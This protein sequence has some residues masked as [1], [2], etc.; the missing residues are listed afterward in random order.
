MKKF[1]LMIMSLLLIVLGTTLVACSGRSPK[2][3]FTTSE[4]LLSVGETI[5]L[6]DYLKVSG[7]IK[8]VVVK[9]EDKTIVSVEGNVVRAENKG[10]TYLYA[11]YS[12][13]VLAKLHIVVKDTFSVP[14][15][16]NV[17]ENGKLLSENGEFT[18]NVV[19]DFYQDDEAPTIASQYKVF[20]NLTLVSSRDGEPTGEREIDTT[21]STNKYVPT[22]FGIYKLKVS[23]VGKGYFDS[24][25][26]S[27]EITFYYG[28]MPQ[29][30]AEDIEWTNDG[31]LTW[32]GVE[33]ARYKV[34]LDGVVL[35]DFLSAT[36]AN[37]AEYMTNAEGGSHA[38]EVVC[39]DLAGEKLPTRS[40]EVQV[41]KLS[42]PTAEYSFDEDLGGRVCF[43]NEEH[44]LNYEIKISANE[45]V[46]TRT[47]T[48]EAEDIELTFDGIDAGL[49]S[50]EIIAHPIEG[51][52]FKSSSAKVENL[53]KLAPMT[54]TGANNNEENSNTWGFVA[55]STTPYETSIIMDVSGTSVRKEGF[56]SG[57]TRKNLTLELSQVGVYT[58]SGRHIPNNE[59]YTS[60]DDVVFAINSDATDEIQVNKLAHI[61]NVMHAYAN[62]KSTFTLA[63]IENATKYEMYVLDGEEYR[64]LAQTYYSV[65]VGENNVVIELTGKIEDVLRTY[66]QDGVITTKIVAKT[67]NDSTTINSSFEKTLTELD[68]PEMVARQNTDM[69]CTWTEDE[70]VGS[71][72][73][74]AYKID[75]ATYDSGSTDIDTTGLE[76]DEQVVDEN[77]YDFDEEGY[78]YVEVYALSGNENVYISATQALKALVCVAVQLEVGQVK[79]GYDAVEEKY[80][81][82]VENTENVDSFEIAIDTF[83]ITNS[84]V[85]GQ[86]S[87]YTLTQTFMDTSK[88]YVVAI[89][90]HS[91]DGDLYLD[92]DDYNLTIKKLPQITK[93]DVSIDDWTFV[94]D[95][96]YNVDTSNTEQKLHIEAVENAK[97][98]KLW[99]TADENNCAG[100][101]SARTAS[102]DL[103]GYSTIDLSFKYYGSTKTGEYFG[104]EDHKIFLDSEVSNLTFTRLGT[105]SNFEYEDG[106]LIVENAES[107]RTSGYT[108]NVLCRNSNNV[109]ENIKVV[110]TEDVV[111]IYEDTEETLSDTN[112]FVETI[113]GVAT[114]D[115]D[116]I[117]NLLKNAENSEINHAYNNAVDYGFAIYSMPN[118]NVDKLVSQYATLK[119]DASKKVAKVEKMSSPE[120][121]YQLSGANIIFNWEEVATSTAAA[122]HTTYQMY[123]N[124]E[125]YGG[126]ISGAT[127][128][129]Y[130]LSEFDLST[131]YSFYVVAE[132][133]YYMDSNNSNTIRIYKLDSIN[134]IKMIS[135]GEFD[136]KLEY[137]IKAEEQGF[138]DYVLVGANDHNT[139]GKIDV[140]GNGT[141][142]LKV[143]GKKGLTSGDMTTSYL[144]SETKNWTLTNMSTLAPASVVVSYASNIL[145][146]DEFAEGV[147]LSKLK[148]AVMFNDGENVA[149]YTTTEHSLN[150]STNTQLYTTISALKEGNIDI[151]VYAFLET[152]EVVAGGNVYYAL[153]QQLENG[154]TEA[155]YFEYNSPLTIKKL[156]TPVIS[157]LAFDDE[158]DLSKANEPDIVVKFTGNYDNNG[159]F[160]ILLNNDVLATTNITKADGVYT[161]TITSDVYNNKI[162]FGAQATIKIFA[163]SETDIPSSMG[164]VNVVRAAK[165]TSVEFE[166]VDR[167]YTQKIVVGIDESHTDLIDGGLV[168]KI[169]YT[170]AGETEVITEYLAI[171]VADI[172]NRVEYSL[173]DFIATNLSDGGKIKVAITTKSSADDS[174]KVY[175]LACAE[176]MESAEYNVLSSVK[177]ANITNTSAGFEIDEDLNRTSTMYVVEYLSSVYEVSYRD[178]KFF[179]EF[180]TS[181]E[182]GSY[183][184]KLYATERNY[185][186]SVPNTINFVLDRIDPVTSVSISRDTTDLSEVTLQWTQIASASGYVLKM[187]D[188]DD[189]VIFRTQ[190]T[191][192][193]HTTLDIF[194]KNF[195]K[196][197]AY[198]E[199]SSIPNDLDVRIGISAIG[200]NANANNSTEYVFNATIK[201]N[202]NS[203]EDVAVNEYGIVTIDVVAGTKYLY[204]FVNG[205]QEAI[206]CSP[207]TIVEAETNQLKI[208]ASF[209]GAELNVGAKVNLEI[210]VLGNISGSSTSS[211]FILDSAVFTTAD[212]MF[213]FEMGVAIESV[214]ID[215]GITDGLALT[216]RKD[217]FDTIFFGVSEDAL[218]NGQVS[219]IEVQHVRDVDVQAV[220]RI[221]GQ[222]LLDILSTEYGDTPYGNVTLYFWAYQEPLSEETNYITNSSV[223]YQFT[224]VESCGYDK[225][226]KYEQTPG[227]D[228]KTDY[229]TAHIFLDKPSGTYFFTGVFVRV[230]NEEDEVVTTYVT[231]LT[232]DYYQGANSYIINLTKLFE[233]TELLKEQFGHFRVDIAT[234]QIT[235]LGQIR[236]S[237]WLSA[238]DDYLEFDRVENIRRL[239]LSSGQ[240]SWT[241]SSQTDDKY[242]V[243]F[244]EE[245]V[246]GEMGDDFTRFEVEDERFTAT[247]FV[248]QNKAYYIAIQA[249]NEDPNVLPSALV[250]VSEDGEP[251]KVTKN[252]I[253]SPLVL[254]NGKFYFEWES[255]GDFIQKL[256]A[257]EDITAPKAREFVAKTYNYPFTFT[258]ADL[259]QDK[260]KIRFKFTQEEGSTT[261]IKSVE[262]N[263]KDL[264][265]NIFDIDPTLEDKIDILISKIGETQIVSNLTKFKELMKNGNHGVASV[266]KIFDDYFE[267]IQLGR[268]SLEYCM[269]GGNKTLNSYW[270]QFSNTNGENVV[271]VGQEPSVRPVRE[272]TS[273]MAVNH[274]KIILRKSYLYDDTYAQQTTEDYVLKVY[275]D[276]GTSMIFTIQKL[277]NTYSL[278]M[279]DSENVNSVS[280]YETDE[281]GNIQVDGNYL[282]F[283][284]NHH[285]NDSLLGVYGDEITKGSYSMELYAVG[286]DITASSKSEY[287]KLTLYGM[288]ENFGI[289]NGIFTWTTQA[290]KNTT[291]VYKRNDSLTEQVEVLDGSLRSLSFN[292]ENGGSGMYDYIQFITIGEING[293]AIG[294]D[295]E[296][297][298][299]E[300]VYKLVMPVVQNNKGYLSINDSANREKLLD[301]FSS[302]PLFTYRVYNDVSTS[303]SYMS[304]T[305]THQASKPVLYET[306]VNDLDEH[307]A[308]YGYRETE[309]NAAKFYV[310]S[311]GSTAEFGFFQEGAD[312]YIK[313][314]YGMEDGVK[315][316]KRMIVSSEYKE[317]NARMMDMADGIGITN[318]MLSW[319][320][321]EGRTEQE[322][323]DLILN[324]DVDVV[325]RVAVAKYKVSNTSIGQTETIL[326][327]IQYFY[328]TKLLFDFSNVAESAS[329]ADVKYLKASV[330]AFAMKV[331]AEIPEGLSE[332]D[333]L[334]LVEGGYAFGNVQYKETNTYVLMS[335]AN[336]LNEIERTQKVEN[337][338]V[339]N[340]KLVWEFVVDG[341]ADIDYDLLQE[342][343]F[344]VVDEALEEVEGECVVSNDTEYVRD[345]DNNIVGTK[346]FITFNENFGQ[347]SEGAQTLTIYATRL[348]DTKHIIRSYGA[349]VEI[350]KLK[351]ITE[352]DFAITSTT[353][354]SIE[355]LDISAYFAR[356]QDIN[357]TIETNLEDRTGLE[358]E[359]IIFT[360][361]KTLLYIL[362]G[363]VET[364][365]TGSNIAGIITITDGSQ[366]VIMKAITT[367]SGHLYSDQTE[368]IVLQRAQW[369]GLIAWDPNIQQFEWEYDGKY[370]IQSS[371]EAVEVEVDGSSYTEIGDATLSAG[372]LYTIV[373]EIGSE[374]VI[375]A[376]VKVEEV[377][378][379]KLYRIAKTDAIGPTYIVEVKYK[380]AGITRT[381]TTLQNHFKP[382]LIDTQVELRLRIKLGPTNIQ[383]AETRFYIENVPGEKIYSVEFNLFENLNNQ[384]GG[385]LVSDGT[386]NKPYYIKT[387]QQFMNLS[388]RMKKDI[389]W[390]EYV[391]NGS[392]IT[393]ESVFYFKLIDDITLDNFSGMLFGNEFGGVIDGRY[394]NNTG[395]Y[396]ITY[397]AIDIGNLSS[398][399][400]IDRHLS[401]TTDRFAKGIALF[402]KLADGAV[403]KNID[404]DITY[405]KESGTISKNSL[406]AGLAITNNGQI[407]NVN[408]VNFSTNL[409]GNIAGGEIDMLYAGLV[410]INIGGSAVIT[411]CHNTADMIV[412][413]YGNSQRNC[414]AGIVSVNYARVEN[415]VIGTS[416]V[417][418]TFKVLGEDKT[419]EIKVSGVATINM[420]N[421]TI[422]NCQ[423]YTLMTAQA[424]DGD[425]WLAYFAGIVAHNDGTLDNT[426]HNYNYV[427]QTTAGTGVGIIRQ[428]E[429]YVAAE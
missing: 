214:G 413:T 386:E 311:I 118:T 226:E 186:Q 321:V 279:L 205:S 150:F 164:S 398:E 423:N 333:C 230:I 388:M 206:T 27:E 362:S 258:I 236:I 103:T 4:E 307:D 357:L 412:N 73:V 136:G 155:N 194:G 201:G 2:A 161:Y 141:I 62:D 17:D 43:R 69:F 202:R 111:A 268:Y 380:D 6:K 381:Y 162:A 266:G 325:Y 48:T 109:V 312:Y 341:Q 313:T 76:V 340:G 227:S 320:A 56:S 346:F 57:V 12:S 247:D 392:Q 262:V 300:D 249:V 365:P 154:N 360:R 309:N 105:L 7:N 38:I 289:E 9:S 371:V 152:Y 348:D 282:M 232:S 61:V 100:S 276:V 281:N 389:D 239:N 212:K 415:C 184:L 323:S 46:E 310:S 122:A 134:K 421:S 190:L 359:D 133:P 68:V 29:I 120:I 293:N 294:V 255:N 119:A 101:A 23:A 116:G 406:F 174:N 192:N 84:V 347:I 182:N 175:H 411:N 261:T 173:A 50:V 93:A 87:K 285:N 63:K 204:R 351:T 47:L 165:I 125:E 270:Y 343:Q 390:T 102:F 144:D 143:V 405:N 66:M 425:D 108:I 318:G 403:I 159:K 394:A 259:V 374:V 117:V 189:R 252:M 424:I 240:L 338:R 211:D 286:N 404:L 185:V 210:L 427:E 299:I 195:S 199:I 74:L 429:I 322:G 332:D 242:Y 95:R 200:Q 169:T 364:L 397:T 209:L 67:N 26:Q 393:E 272:T 220:Y 366:Q 408:L 3:D 254:Q 377:E 94:V 265:S 207:W 250:Y 280:V 59:S 402:E 85:A 401:S 18:W 198:G 244:V 183:D 197:V 52:Y 168:A 368:D 260:I 263:A 55:R 167:K 5:N 296:I 163:L 126:P 342:Y 130:S 112:D 166:A 110:L 301:G 428:G 42:A 409:Q 324:P 246:D 75:K 353:N 39:Y 153:A 106:K 419:V 354:S 70:N 8:N 306:G 375:E 71:Y 335:E 114:I 223:S 367:A 248:G 292:I 145:S 65:S 224:Y 350:T 107:V 54:I 269:V 331:G 45:N 203:V 115:I 147:G 295:S 129:S 97:G 379:T 339:S 231:D 90:A 330:K 49:F 137:Q 20:G 387:K 256:S 345:G 142:S 78:Y 191:G 187:Y 399:I 376:D 77:R 124:G 80:Y 235:S 356:Y 37:I 315:S 121:E 222:K 327:S 233:Q 135:G 213:K 172:T 369:D 113:S 372:T 13:N 316:L 1:R 314:I 225:V 96:Y 32:E 178:D 358:V 36:T 418:T 283:Y 216:I 251:V 208:D 25:E 426:N 81:L 188:E 31:T 228:F 146:W 278:R 407:D 41:L 370:S 131:Y 104:I 35:G 30:L 400:I 58:I 328:T 298:R 304:I 64:K 28:A 171:P 229:A 245:L 40:E 21:V 11:T 243:Y 396:K 237:N 19:S 305:D 308:D 391:E 219:E 385:N 378:T 344:A 410:S 317:T 16:F 273:S 176:Y 180:D 290:N 303:N 139:T 14:T 177:V 140:S 420:E 33:N 319:N 352:E 72:R 349:E 215:L 288:G 92:S 414:I 326:D 88:T 329:D 15:G 53:Y 157:S 384:A 193:S 218:K 363:D 179:F 79:F 234:L 267:A 196:V 91:N 83:R 253:K 334:P 274:Y 284:I 271:Y 123:V 98:V 383:S 275:N 148:Y 34:S 302:S 149:V 60:G 336:S 382:T 291:V 86:T 99:E 132:N 297:Y 151:V 238:T 361:T 277:V 89:T 160:R 44:I 373:E 337:A 22:E 422:R 416:G 257:V 24:S 170:K 156:T 217:G 355:I 395:N 287:F 82:E 127:T 417:S 264:V 221:S 51:Y 158:N 138:V 128:A 181:W 10:A 241:H